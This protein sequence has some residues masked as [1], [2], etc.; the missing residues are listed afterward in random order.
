MRV[1]SKVRDPRKVDF[2]I[3]L[4]L[5]NTY[6]TKLDA[7]CAAAR[8]HTLRYCLCLSVRPA[9]SH[10]LPYNAAMPLIPCPV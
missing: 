8:S 5:E 3:L 7:Y 1:H 10:N 4:V 2:S 6:L 9:H